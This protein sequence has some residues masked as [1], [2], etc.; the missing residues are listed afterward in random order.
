MGQLTELL[1]QYGEIA[2][3]WLDGAN[4]EGP[5]G[6]RQFYDWQRYYQQIRQLQPDAVIAVCGPDVRW[7]GNEAGHTRQNEWSVVPRELLDAEK[8]AEKSQ[9]TDTAEFRTTISSMAE[10]LGSRSV[11]RN[12]DSSRDLVWYP[13][14][15]NLSIRPG[16]FYHPEE[17]T[18]VK[19]AETLFS[20]VSESGRRKRGIFIKC[21]A[22][23]QWGDPPEKISSH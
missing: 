14:E 1:T 11:L 10:D 23:A 15:V 12:Y 13:A 3:V 4:G 16:W 18:A 5:N 6:K 9:Q 7:I 17:D 20:F 2:E 21:S 22:N 8:T 19:S